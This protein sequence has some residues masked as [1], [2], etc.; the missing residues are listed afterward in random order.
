[1]TTT[2]VVW[3][4]WDTFYEPS[5]VRARA[6]RNAEIIKQPDNGNRYLF[7]VSYRPHRPIINATHRVQSVHFRPTLAQFRRVIG[8]FM[9]DSGPKRGEKR[10]DRCVNNASARLCVAL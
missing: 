5:R 4:A 8:V 9:R 3:D 1:M 2:L 6:K 7:R 10:R